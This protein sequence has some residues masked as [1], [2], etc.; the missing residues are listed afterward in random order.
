MEVDNHEAVKIGDLEKNSEGPNFHRGM[1]P[2]AAVREGDRRIDTSKKRGRCAAQFH[3]YH[4]CGRQWMGTTVCGLPKPI[5][6]GVEGAEWEKFYSRSVEMN[7]AANVRHLSANTM[8]AKTFTD[9][10][11][12]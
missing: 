5:F 3:R 4:Q 8:L 11:F 12:F 9:R 1:F 2:D 7:K 10:L 6:K